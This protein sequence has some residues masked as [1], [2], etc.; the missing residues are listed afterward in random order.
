M[1]NIILNLKSVSKAFEKR[2]VLKNIELEINAGESV[3]IC[4]INGV[5]KSTLLRIAAGLLQPDTGSIE[6]CGWN[7]GKVQARSIGYHR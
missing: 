1:N 2:R 4:G 7:I 3:F 5:G 6:I